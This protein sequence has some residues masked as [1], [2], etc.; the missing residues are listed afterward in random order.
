VDTLLRRVVT[1]VK[2]LLCVNTLLGRNV[3][4]VKALVLCGYTARAECDRCEGFGFAWIH[5]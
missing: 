5:C 3:T 1:V 2:A 4:I